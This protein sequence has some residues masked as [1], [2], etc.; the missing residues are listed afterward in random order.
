MQSKKIEAIAYL[1]K[2]MQLNP[3]YRKK[4][5]DYIELVVIEE[6]EMANVSGRII[7]KISERVANNVLILFQADWWEAQEKP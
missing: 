4:W 7:N 2:C 6:L 1:E 5:K 3:E